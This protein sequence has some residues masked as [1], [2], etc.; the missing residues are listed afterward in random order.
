MVYLV[1][2][3][4]SFI[5]GL[6]AYHFFGPDLKSHAMYAENL[7]KARIELAVVRMESAVA[8]GELDAKSVLAKIKALL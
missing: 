2:A 5:A 1:V 7:A 4:V 8:K 3:L 6:A